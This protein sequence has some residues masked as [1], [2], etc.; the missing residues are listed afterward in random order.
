M[1][2]STGQLHRCDRRP[3]RR[4]RQGHEHPRRD[5]HDLLPS[6]HAASR[7]RARRPS[8]A[9]CGR[10]RSTRATSRPRLAREIIARLRGDEA[11]AEAEEHFDRVFRRHEAAATCRPHARAARRRRERRRVPAQASWSAGSASAAPRPAGA[12]SRAAS[13]ST[14]RR[15]R[16]CHAAGRGARR[17]ATSRPASRR[18]SR[19]LSAPRDWA[20]TPVRAIAVTLSGRRPLLHRPSDGRSGR[21]LRPSRLGRRAP[22]PMRRLGIMGR[23][24]HAGEVAGL[25]V[26]RH[27]MRRY[28]TTNLELF[29]HAL[30]P[31]ELPLSGRRAGSRTALASC[32]RPSCG[33]S[34]APRAPFSPVSR[35]AR[36]R[37]RRA[38]RTTSAR[39]ALLRARRTSARRSTSCSP[40]RSP[41]AAPRAA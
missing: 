21:S 16:S 29:L 11:A 32:T 27:I 9:P 37:R 14:A 1:S 12:S 39:C 33:C 34:R 17:R 35:R 3:A 26:E 8:S 5:D 41:G 30:A 7:R 36:L 24:G 22:W 18:S 2:K 31:R 20:Q 23:V 38:R 40:T 4:L 13:R 28:A 25:N 6:A 10:A 15:S 19:A